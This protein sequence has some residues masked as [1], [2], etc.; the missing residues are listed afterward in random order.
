M[1]GMPSILSLLT[2][3]WSIGL[4]ATFIIGLLIWYLGDLVP[5]LRTP[6]EKEIG[7]VAVFIIAMGINAG[8]TL[9]RRRRDTRLMSGVAGEEGQSD[10]SAASVQAEAED[11]VR[12]LRERLQNS[13]GLLKKA[14]KNRGYLYEQPW[15]VLIGPPGSGKTTLLS[16]SGLQFPLAQPDGTGGLTPGSVAGI[17]GTRLCDWWFA[18]EAVLI[19]TAGRFT[20][21]D[22]NETVDRTGWLGFLDLLRK[23]RARQPLNGVIVMISLADVVT[24]SQTERLSH[25]RMIRDRIREITERL[26]VSIP[27]YAVFTK[28]DRIAGFTE[29]FDDLDRDYRRQ[30]WGMTFPVSG[31]IKG[32]ENEFRLLVTRLNDRLY[33]RLQQERIPSRRAA[34]ASF[35]IQI[36]TL[37]EALDEFLKAAF[38]ST[39]L[40]PAPFIRGVYFT[41]SAQEGTPVDRLSSMLA[42]SFGIDQRRMPAL[43]AVSGRPYFVERLI[44]E[45]ILGEARLVAVSPAKMRRQRIVRYSSFAAIGL[46]TV[47]GCLLLWQRNMQNRNAIASNEQAIGFYRSKL[48][49]L[50]L[51][52]VADDN[53]PSILPAL[54]AAREL[55][56]TRTLARNHDF[57][58]DL[59]I[60]QDTNLATTNR[61]IYQAALQRLLLPRLLWRLENQIQEHFSQPA[62]LYEA[63]R[64]YLMLGNQGPLEPKMV[65]DWMLLD[66]ESRYPGPAMKQARDQLLQHLDALLA[67]PLPDMQINGGMVRQ[68]RAEF[69]R[70]TPAERVYGRIRASAVSVPDWSPEQV[71][72]HGQKEF[73]RLS[74]RP[75][76]DTI[77]GFYTS[78]GFRQVL[79]PS[80]SS[81]AQD[82]ANESWVL[83][84][85]DQSM[86]GTTPARLEEGVIA[87]YTAD[88]IRHWDEMLSDL[89][90][91]PFAGHSDLVQRL[92]VL[93]SPQS[94]MRDFLVSI[95]HELTPT[96]DAQAEQNGDDKTRPDPEKARLAG[97][98][99]Q[100]GKSGQ[101]APA[102]GSA[103]DMHYAPL[104]IFTG[105]SG[106]A[107][108]INGV[109]Q[110][111]NQFE[112]A[113]AQLP[114]A[115]N[116]T[117]ILESTQNPVQALEAEAGRQPQPVARWLSQIATAGASTMAGD[118][119]RAAT[120]A[121]TD[122]QGPGQLC[123]DV[124]DG[125]YP[126]DPSSEEDAPFDQFVR[127]F[128]PAG[129][130]DS[131][132]TTQLAAYVDTK[133]PVWKA[134]PIGNTAP[135]VSG[136]ALLQ[137]Q[138]AARIRTL[139]FPGNMA[140]PAVHLRITPVA[141]DS[142]STAVNLKFGSM[143]AAWKAGA[144]GA[145][146]QALGASI[147]WPGDNMSNITLD[148]VPE[149]AFPRRMQGPWAFFHLLDS[150][151]LTPTGKP[152]ELTATFRS[153]DREV[154]YALETSTPEQV[155]DRSLFV[156]FHCPA[157]R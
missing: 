153:G 132:F 1:N 123:H 53:L 55:P 13:L 112:G 2:G 61:L 43:R 73:T 139:L 69:S 66:W 39:R 91:V 144:N 81:A 70:V 154:T 87:L 19:D 128:A 152:D 110:I 4:L 29:F 89:A 34:I 62:F 114:N 119:H 26:G 31:D 51:D 48:E 109:M 36:E 33:E 116:P 82:V 50:Q 84:N 93:S 6:L 32:F 47:A 63:T 75:M 8:L 74:G 65:R 16:Q 126:F 35:P 58:P 156:H 148:F 125:H 83:G 28:A 57:W 15:F 46:F 68:T 80:L 25:A 151:V 44:R 104:V 88:Y 3:R 113:I 118:A 133:G 21:Q 78:A 94:P 64:I 79:L 45:V 120:A 138:Q 38:G 157:L 92:Y 77:P 103:I 96:A 95:T 49:H 107:P 71:L 17:G 99:A 141:A 27:V 11:E 85:T 100:N 86:N 23:T 24:V 20:T 130:L 147:T 76:S 149:A 14:R 122:G 127:L 12:L 108:P 7:I 90:L 30:V 22:S 97:L 56:D 145:L 131:Y 42:R 121:Y 101:T 5:G 67:I 143:M 124:V 155:L 117:Q 40:D 140:I 41:S 18:D 10:D 37:T 9:Y 111:L 98:F 102:P 129:A 136:A 137:F 54:N 135:P 60:S 52:P 142:Q 105:R 59:A 150:G 146:G 134:H 115:D 106:Q 72:G